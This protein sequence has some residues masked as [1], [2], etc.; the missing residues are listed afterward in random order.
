MLT[1]LKLQF[2]VQQ[3][4]DTIETCRNESFYKADSAR[5]EY[6]KYL[7]FKTEFQDAILTVCRYCNTE[8]EIVGKMKAIMLRPLDMTSLYRRQQKILDAVE[9]IT[10]ELI[11]KQVEDKVG[12]IEFKSSLPE[13]EC[14]QFCGKYFEQKKDELISFHR[15]LEKDKPRWWGKRYFHRKSKGGPRQSTKT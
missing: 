11:R 15:Q 2:Y 14:R 1:S 7:E 9:E 13:E 6:V 4:V 5:L 3:A 10:D 12:V 8:K